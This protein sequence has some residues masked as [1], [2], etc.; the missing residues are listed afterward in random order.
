MFVK[1]INVVRLLY[2]AHC[3]QVNTSI[4]Q[5]IFFKYINKLHIIIKS[6]IHGGIYHIHNIN[7]L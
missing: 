5:I 2:D 4:E 1:F 6:Y 3:S 7:N